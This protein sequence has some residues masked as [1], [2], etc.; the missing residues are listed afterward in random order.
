[1]ASA[2][3]PSDDGYRKAKNL[4]LLVINPNT[5][6]FVTEKVRAS[7]EAAAG[8]SVEII[9]VTGRKGVPI[10]STRSECAIAAMEAIEL[11]IEYGT[12]TDG[13]LLGISF[14]SGLDEIRELLPIPIVGMSE[15]GMLA[16]CALSRR[17]SMVTFGERAVPL[18]DELIDHYKLKDRSAGTVSLPPLT[19][20]ELENPLLTVGRLVEK[21][22]E[23][24]EK[25]GAES[26]VLAG[27]IFAGLAPVLKN[28]VSI[29]VVDGVVAGVGLLAM[30]HSL[31]AGKPK[32]GGYRYPRRSEPAGL[33]DSLTARFRSFPTR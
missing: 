18:Y 9:A 5:S 19:R 20:E 31:N 21:I 28:R 12:G 16:S 8:S 10:V 33:P 2:G 3:I 30:L 32:L 11:A 7:A 1:M 14:D 24:A 22:E 17:F 29:P 26:V 15:A 6:A 4:K 25:R 13:I 27:A 23:A